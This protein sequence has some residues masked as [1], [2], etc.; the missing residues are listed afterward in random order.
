[1]LT[2]NKTTVIGTTCSANGPTLNINPNGIPTCVRGATGVGHTM[3]SVVISGAFSGNVVYTSRRTTVI[4]DRVCS[5]I[6]GRFRL[7]GMCFTGPRRVRRLRSIIVG[8]TGANMEPGIINVR[9]HGVTRLTKLGIPTGA[10]VLITRLPNIKTRCPVS[11]RG[12]S[13]MLTVVGSSDARRN[14]R[15]YGRVL[16]LNNLNRSTTLRAHHGS[17]V[18]QFKG[19]VGTYHILVGSPSSRTN[20]NSL[21][22]GGVTSLALNYK[23]CNEGSISRGISTLSLLGIGAITGEEGGVR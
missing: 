12:L 4:S 2:A 6:G 19:R 1:M 23:S 10:G 11:E 7:R 8:S 14:V 13:P 22:G 21:C 20:V 17:L 15:L 16:S 5:R 3:G 9:T 18:R